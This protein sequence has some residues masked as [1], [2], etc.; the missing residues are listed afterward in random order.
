MASSADDLSGA[1]QHISSPVDTLATTSACQTGGLFWGGNTLSSGRAGLCPEA[2][3]G[4]HRYQPGK[5][6]GV[7]GWTER[8]SV[9][10]LPRL[11]TSGSVRGVADRI[12][13]RNRQ[14]LPRY[15]KGGRKSGTGS[16][17]SAK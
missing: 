17:D 16:E 8:L 1:G 4:L 9:F 15:G 12:W 5:S 10:A 6:L 11:Q 7:W 14:H 3:D 2:R 13:G